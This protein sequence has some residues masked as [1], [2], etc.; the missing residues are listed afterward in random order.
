[1]INWGQIRDK[2][3]VRFVL[4]YG[5]VISIPLLIDYYIIK[6]FLTSFRIEIVFRE[7]VIVWITCVLLGLTLALYVWSRLERHWVN[8]KS[9]CE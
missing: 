1:M 6:F 5:L 7:L 4:S 2:G 9:L 3:K 8:K